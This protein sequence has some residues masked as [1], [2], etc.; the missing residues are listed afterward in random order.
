MLTYIIMGIVLIKRNLSLVFFAQTLDLLF[1]NQGS[2]I[3]YDFNK[4]NSKV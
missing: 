2:N 4:F 3:I 1:L